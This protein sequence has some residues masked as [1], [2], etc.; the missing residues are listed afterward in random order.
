[1]PYRILKEYDLMA[2]LIFSCGHC[3]GRRYGG[4]ERVA[5]TVYTLSCIYCTYL[6]REVAGSCFKTQGAQLGTCDDLEGWNGRVGGRFKREGLY[7][8]TYG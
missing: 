6:Y 2:E 3:G 1:M 8:H 5:L 7:I 4:I